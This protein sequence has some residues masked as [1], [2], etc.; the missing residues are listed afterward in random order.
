MQNILLII[1]MGTL[2]VLAFWQ[3][4]KIS[5]LNEELKEVNSLCKSQQ[6]KYGKS[7]EHFVP[8]IK[9]FPASK[10]DVHFIG[11]PVDFVSFQE[12]A[13]RFIEVKTGESQL[14]SKQKKIKQL[15]EEGRVMWCDLRY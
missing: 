14:S 8:F 12:D 10:E 11:C 6:V 3:Y 2:G 9:D 4:R 1:G 15:V 5:K 13:I 7:F